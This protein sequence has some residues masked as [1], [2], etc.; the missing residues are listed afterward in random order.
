MSYSVTVCIPLHNSARWVENVVSNVQQLPPSVTEILVS[1]RTMA[2]NAAAVLRSRLADDPR[3]RVI[4]E[5]RGCWWP[6]HCQLLLD[7]AVG[8]LVMLLP[9]DDTPDAT[10]VTGLVAALD[11]HPDA[12][13]AFGHITL[14]DEDGHTPFRWQTFHPTPGL[15]P[16]AAAVALLVDGAAWL[17]FRGLLRKQA[18]RDAGITLSSPRH[19]PR[20]GYRGAD[21][22]WVLAMALAGGVVYEPG[23]DVRK[24]VHG[25]S[26]TSL[27][28]TPRPGARELAAVP[29]LWR[30]GNRNRSVDTVRLLLAG[31]RASLRQ[32]VRSAY[33]RVW[34]SPESTT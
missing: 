7:E 1:D 34:P 30:H 21:E 5:R 22:L 26:A 8:D 11:R 33:H 18:V 14:V 29:V 19:F 28:A 10:W 3:V 24:R 27:T 13:L 23:T 6:E 15:I 9:H 12:L 17:G 31:T 25:G 2:D 32:L 16:P 20:R 4:E